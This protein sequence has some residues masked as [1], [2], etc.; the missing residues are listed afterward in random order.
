MIFRFL[1]A[2]F[3]LVAISASAAELKVVTIRTLRGE[4][5]EMAHY[6]EAKNP[7]HSVT[8]SFAKSNDIAKMLGKGLN[9]DLFVLDQEDL[10]DST[11]PVTPLVSNDPAIIAAKETEVVL[12]DLKDLATDKVEKIVVLKET[13]PFSIKIRDYLEKLKLLETVKPK[14]QEAADA[15]TA[16]QQI[17]AGT[18]NLGFAYSGDATAAPGIRVL[19]KLPASEIPS[20][21]MVAGV[22]PRSNQQDL[23]KSFL[24]ALQSTIAKKLFENGGYTVLVP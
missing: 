19:Q 1:P 10:P 22:N 5:E 14:F 23:A 15:K 3:L 18:R 16:F 12:T 2:I 21:I 24:Q 20:I 8:L 11:I 9:G 4:L 13:R 7:G 6:F 17:A